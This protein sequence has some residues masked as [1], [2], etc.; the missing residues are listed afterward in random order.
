[1]AHSWKLLLGHIR[2]ND[3][4]PYILRFRQVAKRTP[5]WPM[6][7]GKTDVNFIVAW[8]HPCHST[9][10]WVCLKWNT[11]KPS[12]LSSCS[13]EFPRG[14]STSFSKTPFS[15]LAIW[16]PIFHFRVAESKE[17]GPFAGTWYTRKKSSIC[18]IVTRGEGQDSPKIALLP[19]CWGYSLGLFIIIYIIE[20]YYIIYLNAIYI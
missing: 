12:D 19:C 7:K 10:I 11:P 17:T 20:S 16:S 2:N 14:G 15:G 1:M 9:C 6:C 4:L 18:V 13:H 8:R 3:E 5:N